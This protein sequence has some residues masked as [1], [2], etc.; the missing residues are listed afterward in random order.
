MRPMATL[1]VEGWELESAEERHALAPDSFH[2]PSR[3]ERVSLQEGQRVQLLFLM[4]VRG[5]IPEGIMCEK[6]WVTIDE[7]TQDGYRGTLDS[8]PASSNAIAPGDAVTFEPKHI[9]CVLVPK[10][11]PQHPEYNANA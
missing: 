9:S 3:D 11:D 4:L 6:M 7:V 2:I 8:M 5:S 10:S 1:D